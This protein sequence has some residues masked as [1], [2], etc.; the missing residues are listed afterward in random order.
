MS[1]P[2]IAALVRIGMT[3]RTSSVAVH[4]INFHKIS[5]TMSNTHDRT[6]SATASGALEYDVIPEAAKA[7]VAQMNAASNAGC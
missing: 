2:R 4:L 1:A 5:A 7:N 3:T 6:A